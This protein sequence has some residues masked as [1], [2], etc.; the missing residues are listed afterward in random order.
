MELLIIAD[1]LTGAL[2]TAI[3]FVKRGI[4]A[5]VTTDLSYDFTRPVPETQVLVIDAETRHL[6]PCEAK[7]TVSDLVARAK[8]SG[9]SRFYK[10]TDSALR[11]NVAGELTALLRASGENELL[12]FPAY[13]EMGRTTQNGTHYIDGIPVAESV[14]GKD[15]LNPIK[16]SY[17]PGLFAGIQDTAATPFPVHTDYLPCPEAIRRI[18]IF[19]AASST[20]IR[21]HLQEWNSHGKGNILAGC[22]GLANVLAALW[23]GR[24]NLPPAGELRTEGLLVLCGSLNPITLRQL[25]YAESKGFCRMR[26][27]LPLEGRL[28]S[29]EYT[30]FLRE[31]EAACRKGLNV[32]VDT[33][34][35]NSGAVPAAGPEG[36]SSTYIPQMFGALL[37]RWLSWGLNHTVF[38]TGGDTLLGCATAV[39]AR[40]ITPV[41][42]L[43]PG[44]PLNRMET[45]AGPVP[46]ISKSGGFGGETL[47][48]D[49]CSLF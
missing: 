19:D 35:P 10:K 34:G 17:V 26:L 33:C 12:F 20:D 21:E 23:P 16:T 32:I 31:F 2:D 15:P 42:E 9:V 45:E 30:P 49:I 22:A 47:L 48:E 46:V 29:P 18:S 28:D 13:P 8:K 37:R 3:P 39:G 38:I 36:A 44:V 5:Q 27:P 1:D 14:F 43:F 11:G 7:R 41:R 40:S 25:S 24:R 4:A 6:P